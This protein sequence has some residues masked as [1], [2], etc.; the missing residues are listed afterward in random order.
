[1]MYG[2]KVNLDK[3]KQTSIDEMIKYTL[4]NLNKRQDKPHL[5]YFKKCCL[6]HYF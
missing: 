5:K 1:M 6:K 2:L 4:I 3:T